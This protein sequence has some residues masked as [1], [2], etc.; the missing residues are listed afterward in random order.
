MKQIII[1]TAMRGTC[2]EAMAL[3]L[4]NR[5]MALGQANLLA[6]TGSGQ[7]EESILC[8]AAINS[9]Y[10]HG[11]IPVGKATS[12]RNDDTCQ[13]QN[14]Q[15]LKKIVDSYFEGAEPFYKSPIELL[16]ETLAGTKEKITIVV[17]GPL[18][19]IY[20][21]LLSQPDAY[22]AL[23]GADLVYA[24][25]DRFVV[26]AGCFGPHEDSDDMHGSIRFDLDAARGTVAQSPV[27]VVFCGAEIGIDPVAGADYQ[28]L[29]LRNP[30]RMLYTL[31]KPAGGHRSSCPIAV[32]YAIRGSRGL[33]SE[34][35]CVSVHISEEG[36]TLYRENGGKHVVLQHLADDNTVISA[37]CS[38]VVPAKHQ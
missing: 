33:W 5:L 2:G 38:Y 6:V 23:S 7:A 3:S 28:S 1:D 25:V 29:S 13:K 19:N 27:P 34:K 21:L 10:G 30:V 17:L 15:F 32:L 9:Y 31:C 20:E 12:G 35:S 11:D 14:S 18:T 26:A 8:A 24:K 37:I 36:N 16:R 22:S 4:A